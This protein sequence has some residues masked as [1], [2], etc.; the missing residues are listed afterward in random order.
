MCIFSPRLTF[1]FIGIKMSL[2]SVK[3]KKKLQNR[4][5]CYILSLLTSEANDIFFYY[6]QNKT[7]TGIDA[8]LNKHL[9][10]AIEISSPSEVR[11]FFNFTTLKLSSRV[12]FSKYEIECNVEILFVLQ[13]IYPC[14][15]KLRI[16][17]L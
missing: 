10:T 16:K 2:C 13:N 3:P 12:R 4:F 1:I 9:L 5:T 14:S 17:P 6:M 7:L 15:L 11:C 8:F